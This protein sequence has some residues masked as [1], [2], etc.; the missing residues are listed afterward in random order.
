MSFQGL[1]EGADGD[2]WVTKHSRTTGSMR[3]TPPAF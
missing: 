1:S 3:K 2:G